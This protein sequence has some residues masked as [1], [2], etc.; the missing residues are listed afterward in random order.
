[1]KSADKKKSDK[2]KMVKKKREGVMKKKKEAGVHRKLF[3][4]LLVVAIILGG[5]NV[6]KAKGWLI[7]R[8]LGFEISGKVVDLDSL[9]LEQKIA[10][11]IIVAGFSENYYPLRNMQV[12][13]IHL[14]ARQNVWIF[15]NTIV[16][17]QYGMPIP[18]FVTA[19]LEGCITP[20]A[21]IRN[22]TATSEIKTI[23]EA[24]EAGFREGEFLKQMG[25][26]LNFAPVVDL[27]DQ[28]WKCRVF[29]GDEKQI[30]ELAQSYI[31]GLQD[32]GIIA[33]AKHYPGKTLVMKD[34]H[35]FIVNAAIDERDIYP[36][37]YLIEKGKIKA[38]MVSHVITSG[39]VD[40][41]G[42]PSVVSKKVIDDIKSRFD[43]LIVS[44][45]IHMLGLQNFYPSVDEMYVAVFKAGNDVILN[46]D[47]DPNEIYR[48]IQIVA[49]AVRAGE[50][51]EEQIDASV[52][53]ILEVK[54]FAVE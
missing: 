20:F 12:G 44:D 45:E 40:S 13:G 26:N 9:T 2:K 16:D 47:R 43:G 4:I 50:I 54:G 19:D 21:N 1:M 52:A 29:P 42:V 3:F 7:P 35:K 23:G 28:I 41:E 31:L 37:Q 48:M 22:F 49:E 39:E 34:P 11:M 14:Y 51:P 46:F 33:T 30:A 36:Y 27:E 53:K 32:N 38:I 24:F 25:F 17:F 18:L 5:M 15:N 6:V 8:Q 10:Q